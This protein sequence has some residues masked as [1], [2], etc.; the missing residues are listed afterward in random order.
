ME[1]IPLGNR[2][3]PACFY[4]HMAVPNA[5]ADRL[6]HEFPE[7]CGVGLQALPWGKRAAKCGKVRRTTRTA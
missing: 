7:H 5:S 6:V 2:H 1:E 3:L 4:A